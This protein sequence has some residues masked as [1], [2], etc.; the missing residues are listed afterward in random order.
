MLTDICKKETIAISDYALFLIARSAEG[1]L[2]DAKKIL[3]QA[4]AI[5]SGNV[6]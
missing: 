5:S 6:K 3:D 1:S 4:I 2:R